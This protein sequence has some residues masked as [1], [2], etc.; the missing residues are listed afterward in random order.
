MAFWAG[1]YGTAVEPE[2]WIWDGTTCNRPATVA[3]DFHPGGPYDITTTGV[4]DDSY[5]EQVRVRRWLLLGPRA[6]HDCIYTAQPLIKWGPTV[7]HYT[8]ITREGWQ[9]A[10]GERVMYWV[11][12]RRYLSWPSPWV[13]AEHTV[14]AA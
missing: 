8:T 7:N 11:R 10:L 4:Y 6:G 9:L 1:F 13:Q 14:H 5:I 3:G 12:W 2:N